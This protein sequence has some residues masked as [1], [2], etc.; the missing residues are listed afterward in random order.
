MASNFKP[1][2][3]NA[4][5]IRGY[6]DIKKINVSQNPRAFQSG[7]FLWLNKVSTRYQAE[8]AVTSATNP[9]TDFTSSTSNAGD[10]TSIVHA[11]GVFAA[12]F[13]GMSAEQRIPQQL[14][15]FGLFNAPQTPAAVA[16]DASA[17]FLPYYDEGIASVL[18]GPTLSSTGLLTAAIDPGT[19][20]ALD[21]FQNTNAA[22]SGFYDGSGQLLNDQLYY[23]YNNCVNTTGT[24][25]DAIG[26]VVE[27]AEIG[28]N[29]LIIKFSSQVLKTGSLS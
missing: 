10:A 28:A 11:G 22:L 5:V 27:R 9:G 16:M 1:P 21:G 8:P 7:S 14:N 13:L 25:A 19:L 17:P 3:G 4:R 2:A 12:L 20:V 29:S 23:L 6:S 24:A 18:I 26:V 15:N